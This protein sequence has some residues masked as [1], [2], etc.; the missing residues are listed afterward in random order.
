MQEFPPCKIWKIHGTHTSSCQFFSLSFV[1]SLA[2]HCSKTTTKSK[3]NITVRQMKK[4][5]MGSH[6]VLRQPTTN[7]RSAAR[8]PARLR[9]SLYAYATSAR[10]PSSCH[11][12][13]TRGAADFRT[14]VRPACR[15]MA[16]GSRRP[17]RD[18]RSYAGAARRGAGVPIVG[19]RRG[20]LGP[21][22]SQPC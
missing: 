9:L 7:Q 3:G 21:L 22:P 20:L 5:K 19:S 14:K 1:R 12:S 13:G 10:R 6:Q 8:R 18:P 4:M 17:R 2:A 15:C 11:K 16:P